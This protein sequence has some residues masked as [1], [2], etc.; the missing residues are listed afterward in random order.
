MKE[1]IYE[2]EKCGTTLERSEQGVY[3]WCERCRSIWNDGFWEGA[4]SYR[5]IIAIC[6]ANDL[7]KLMEAR[8]TYMVRK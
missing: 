7:T 3:T 6:D 8:C 4:K 1:P 2:C 5:D